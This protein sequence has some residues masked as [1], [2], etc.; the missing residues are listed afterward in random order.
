[1]E[2]WLN[3]IIIHKPGRLT[4]WTKT[5]RRA[6]KAIIVTESPIK[7]DRAN[8]TDISLLN[9]QGK[10][11]YMEVLTDYSKKMFKKHALHDTGADHG[12][13]FYPKYT[14]KMWLND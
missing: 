10:K 2:P 7:K 3:Q 6:S 9:S 1:M 11:F 14:E 8:K 12:N 13:N 4:C 5:R